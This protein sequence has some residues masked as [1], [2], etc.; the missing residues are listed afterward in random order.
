M[1]QSIKDVIETLCDKNQ[2][3]YVGYTNTLFVVFF[4]ECSVFLCVFVCVGKTGVSVFGFFFMVGGG[5]LMGV[6]E[7]EAN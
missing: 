2:K 6:V 3:M 1:N 7:N 5:N 4:V